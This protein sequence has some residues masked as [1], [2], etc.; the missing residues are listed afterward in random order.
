M[1]LVKVGKSIN[2]A[3]KSFSTRIFFLL[4]IVLKD[5]TCFES[6]CHKER[7]LKM[8]KCILLVFTERKPRQACWLQAA[9]RF[10]VCA[11]HCSKF[12]LTSGRGCHL[13]PLKF[14]VTSVDGSPKHLAILC[15]SGS[16]SKHTLQSFVASWTCHGSSVTEQGHRLAGWQLSCQ[17]LPE[18]SSIIYSLCSPINNALSFKQA[19]NKPA[20]MHCWFSL[21]T[22]F[23]PLCIFTAVRILI[24][25][26]MLQQLT[27]SSF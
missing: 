7:E 3:S 22:F 10:P 19:L 14:S 8:V 24:V 27:T 17:P 5:Q 9:V 12:L 11:T 1:L 18:K 23:S 4:V 21:L 16:P 2:L 20:K 6:G 25:C 26:W 13:K 15:T